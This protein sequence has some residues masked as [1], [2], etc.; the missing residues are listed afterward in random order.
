M[1]QTG[2]DTYADIADNSY[3]G[4]AALNPQTNWDSF[5][6]GSYDDA[7]VFATSRYLAECD[8]ERR[9]PVGYTRVVEDLRLQDFPRRELQPVYGEI[10]TP[11]PEF[12]L[13]SLT[14]PLPLRYTTWLQHS[15][16][17]LAEVVVSL[18]LHP[19]FLTLL[20]I[21]LLL[22]WWSSD[23]T[24][25]NA[26]TNELFL[27]TSAHAYSKTGNDTYLQNAL[28]VRMIVPIAFNDHVLI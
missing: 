24:Y 17:T 23:H 16:M 8:D 28:T 15:G 19:P 25:K 11:C 3:I 27:L 20:L 13:I 2:T 18:H 10:N 7:Q 1:L 6:G 26:I 21:C 14:S 5:F 22:V 12:H 4:Q 9:S